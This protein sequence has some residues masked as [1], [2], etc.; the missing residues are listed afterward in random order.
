MSNVPRI[1][2]IIRSKYLSS[3]YR[4]YVYW[5]RS[6][7]FFD[8]VPR[9]TQATENIV[10]VSGLINNESVA[11][12]RPLLW[13]SLKLSSPGFLSINDSLIVCIGNAQISR[14]SHKSSSDYSPVYYCSNW[15]VY[16]IHFVFRPNYVEQLLNVED[17][18]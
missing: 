8:K 11:L 2:S 16:L 18:G 14:H 3:R 10:V 4:K 17:Y 5:N 12:I 7:R 6:I 9:V 13:R 1:G 15:I